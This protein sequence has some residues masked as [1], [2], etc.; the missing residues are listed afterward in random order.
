[1]GRGASP[2]NG[3]ALLAIKFIVSVAGPGGKC[4]LFVCAVA[5]Q[6]RKGCFLAWGGLPVGWVNSVG[7]APPWVLP[8]SLKTSFTVGRFRFGPTLQR[9]VIYL[10]GRAWA[11]R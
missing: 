2:V 9:R 11:L 8:S 1:M 4:G 6:V 5:R 10:A 3:R 7:T